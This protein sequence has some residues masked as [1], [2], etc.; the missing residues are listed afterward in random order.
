M[1][2]TIMRLATLS[3]AAACL[4]LTALLSACGGVPDYPALLSQADSAFMQGRYHE[5][6]SLMDAYS[7]Q[8]AEADEDD[9]VRA[10][11]HLLQLEQSFC[12]GSLAEQDFSLADSL[13]RCY[14]DSEE[15]VKHAK[16]LLFVG[17]LYEITGNYPAALNNYLQAA[18][19]AEQQHDTRLLC[20]VSRCQGDIYFRQRR[21]QECIPFYRFYYSLA[22][23]NCDTLRMAY[24]SSYMGKVNI[25]NNNEDSVI[26]YF[27]QSIA[28]AKGQPHEQDIVG[29]VINDL[30]NVYI[31]LEEYDSAI[32][33]MPRRK[34]SYFN[35]GLLHYSQEHLDSAEYYFNNA[36][37]M[38]KW[39]GE[40]E[41]LDYLVSIEKQKGNLASSVLYYDRLLAAK[42]SLYLT[43]AVEMTK[44]T[45]AQ[46]NYNRLKKER[47]QEMD[48]WRRVTLILV[49]VIISCILLFFVILFCWKSFR[50]RKNI[51]LEHEKNKLKEAN[52]QKQQSLEQLEENKKKLEQLEQQLLQAKRR[53]DTEIVQKI[54]ID[55]EL[56]KADNVSIEALQHKRQLMID[57]FRRQ[58]LYM[59]ITRNVGDHVVALDNETWEHLANLID[60]TYDHFTARLLSL[61]SLKEVE[62]RVC[63]LIKMGIQPV[64]IGPMVNRR[65]STIS[66]MCK[67]LYKKV[68]D[69]EGTA[70]DFVGFISSF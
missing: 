60:K 58:P 69:R 38:H 13:E 27:K 10:Y 39:Q 70:K 29:N 40:V 45:E 1:K 14:R 53:G 8:A 20:L 64:D 56:I 66:M 50:Q 47:D 34:E 2:R 12:H 36:L 54:W 17:N 15:P 52:I 16:T 33:I 30:S 6:D 5:G 67:R 7:R 49:F 21:L 26:Y 61:T 28:L 68:T 4:V 24:A 65:K 22:K 35:W 32:A 51:E 42:D 48:Y 63:Y 41:A 37:G 19:L 46:F 23:R 55:A 31:Q 57:N 43:N 3:C 44:Q 11:R 9:D 62:L 25:I 59:M 18:T